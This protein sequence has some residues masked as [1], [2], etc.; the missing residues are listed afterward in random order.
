MN[1]FMRNL[2]SWKNSPSVIHISPAL[3]L[4]VLRAACPLGR[5]IERRRLV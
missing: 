3:L 1:L 4:S 2:A 5:D